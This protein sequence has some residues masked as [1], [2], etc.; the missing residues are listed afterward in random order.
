MISAPP[1]CNPT[2]GFPVTTHEINMVSIVPMIRQVIDLAICFFSSRR[3]HTRSVSAFLLNR[4]SD[5]LDESP[6]RKTSF[7]EI[8]RGGKLP[9][10][11][12]SPAISVRS[13][14][15][16]VGKECRAPM[17][18]QVIDLEICLLRDLPI[19]DALRSNCSI[20]WPCYTQWV[21]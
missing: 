6:E 14:E 12:G 15:R 20:N 17:I 3:R 2:H 7:I 11:T 9:Y 16:R 19:M 18:R 21:L 8:S 10:K 4:S 1:I 5:L 13:E